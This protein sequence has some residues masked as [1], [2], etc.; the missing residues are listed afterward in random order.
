[1]KKEINFDKIAVVIPC[2]KVKKTIINVIKKIDN[3]IN[4]IYIVDDNCPEKTGLYLKKSFKDK[5]IKIIEHQEN[6]GVGAAVITG[7]KSAIKDGAEI[8]VKIDGDN[9]MDTSLIFNFII[10]IAKGHADYTKGNRFFNLEEIFNMPKGRIL[11][12]LILSFLTKLSSGYWNI[13]DPTNGYTAIHKNVILMLPLSKID[14]RFFFESDILFRLNTIKA[15][16]L[17]IPIPARYGNEISNLKIGKI[18][19]EFS[20]KHL[21][22]FLKRIFYNY[23]LRDLSIASFE[24]PLALIFSLLGLYYGVSKW[25]YFYNT[26]SSATPGAVMLPALLI[27]LGI[28]FFLSFLQFDINSTPVNPIHERIEKFR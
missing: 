13:F 25:I 4:K 1:M 27:F 28:Q 6:Q 17:D 3:R 12:N 11:G 9:Q 19:P 8:I 10:P 20:I 2:Y 16:V 26:G 22:N 5:R 21:R 15:V 18:L 23:Y 7:Y 24:L 14:K